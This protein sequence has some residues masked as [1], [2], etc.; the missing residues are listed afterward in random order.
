MGQG[1][2]RRWLFEIGFWTL[3]VALAVGIALD[4]CFSRQRSACFIAGAILTII[5]LFLA[6]RLAGKGAEKGN[7]K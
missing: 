2:M 5:I 7:Q 4:L 1:K 3:V 6:R